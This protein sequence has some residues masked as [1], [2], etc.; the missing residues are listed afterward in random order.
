MEGNKAFL[1]TV[2]EASISASVG[3]KYKQVQTKSPSL[4]T[5]MSSQ[6]LTPTFVDSLSFHCSLPAL[7]QAPGCCLG[8]TLPRNFVFAGSSRAF[9]LLHPFLPKNHEERSHCLL[10][11]LER[12]GRKV[13]PRAWQFASCNITLVQIRGESTSYTE[14]DTVNMSSCNEKHRFTHASSMISMS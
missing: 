11:L 6:T 14:S 1:C 2:Q 3:R 13:H 7:R 8:A 4:Q 5:K 10:T 12:F 9:G